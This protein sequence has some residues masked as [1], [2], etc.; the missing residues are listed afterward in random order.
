MVTGRSFT[1][2]VRP[3][4]CGVGGKVSGPEGMA[5]DDDTRTVRP[6][7]V[8]RER[9]A[10]DRLH[11]E[12]RKEIARHRHAGQAFGVAV[13]GELRVA[14]AIIAVVGGQLGE[15][16]G[17]APAGRDSATAAPC[18]PAALVSE[19]FAIQTRRS[20]S[21][22]GSGRSSSA[23]ITL[24]TVALAPMPRPM[25]RIAKSVKPRIA[26][27]RAQRVAEILQQAVHQRQSA[28]VAMR[29]AQ[30]RQRRRVPG[31]PRDAPDPASGRGAGA[32]PPTSR[33]A[34]RAPAS[35]RD[36]R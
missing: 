21:R 12:E 31:A 19:P 18:T 36:P 29:L 27:Q 6:A 28:H 30:L 23:L 10:E 9:S 13:A 24:K 1:V 7:F 3:T 8:G 16:V 14:A 33:D 22:N 4:M 20:A 26:P 2:S 15:R 25:I 34:R 17:S 35:A 32:P 5:H 11:A